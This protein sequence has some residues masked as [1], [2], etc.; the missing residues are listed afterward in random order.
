MECLLQEGGIAAIEVMSISRHISSL[1]LRRRPEPTS[2]GSMEDGKRAVAG[3]RSPVYIGF[4]L[5]A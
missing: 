1:C 2:M 3:L 4:M 5:F